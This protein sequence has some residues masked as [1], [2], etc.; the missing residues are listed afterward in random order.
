MSEESS[1]VEDVV[2][3]YKRLLAL[4]RSSLEANQSTLASKDKQISQLTAALEELRLSSKQKSFNNYRDDENAVLPRSI[5]R[6]VDVNENI[7]ILLEYENASQEWNCFKS[8]D[9]LSDFIQRI[10][11]APLTI[12]HRCLTPF[13]SAKCV[14]PTFYYCHDIS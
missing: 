11:G 13:E 3:K 12:P 5:L 8:E 1:Q 6:R 10:P 9:E 2:A 4:A 14:S 7:W